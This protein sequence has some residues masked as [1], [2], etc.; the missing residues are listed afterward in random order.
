MH[1]GHLEGFYDAPFAVKDDRWLMIDHEG[2]VGSTTE[3]MSQKKALGYLRTQ[4]WRNNYTVCITTFAFLYSS[5]ECYIRA[6]CPIGL[7]FIVHVCCIPGC[8]EKW[9]ERSGTPPWTQRVMEENEEGGTKLL[10]VGRLLQVIQP[11]TQNLLSHSRHLMKWVLKEQQTREIPT[12]PSL[13]VWNDRV[14][15]FSRCL[16]FYEIKYRWTL[17]SW[18][19]FVKLK[20]K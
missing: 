15:R 6:S 7:H 20:P 9:V 18:Q 11:E 14:R 2:T 5:L 16:N 4:T 3:D 19:I 8:R 10:K 12:G 17:F 1:E 13:I